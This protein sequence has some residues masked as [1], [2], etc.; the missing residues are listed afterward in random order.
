MGI[1]RGRSSFLYGAP[2]SRTITVTTAAAQALILG[3]A[4]MAVTVYVHGTG[5]LL[6]GDSSIAV[7]SANVLYPAMSYTWEHIEDGFPLFLRAESVQTIV[8]VTEYSVP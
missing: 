4:R 6:W 3:S 2:T 5:T 7:N 1:P 8:T